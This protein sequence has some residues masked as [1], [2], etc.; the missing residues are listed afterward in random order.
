MN[1]SYLGK[2]D[3]MVDNTIC[4]RISGQNSPP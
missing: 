1:A 2:G 3:L 4:I